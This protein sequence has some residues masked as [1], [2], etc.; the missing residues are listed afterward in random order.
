MKPTLMLIGLGGLGSALLDH[1]ARLGCVGRI[2]AAG[3]NPTRGQ[4]RCNLA[5][6]SA[7]A[8]GFSPDIEFLPLDL[9]QIEATAAAVDA[10]KPDIIFNA[11]SLQTWWLHELLPAEAREPLER[12][13]FGMW[14]PVHLTLAM[15]LM[16]ALRQA[17]YRGVT[18]TAPFPDVVNNILKRLGLAPTAGV[19]NLEEIV[20]KIQ[21]LAARRLN[22]ATESVRV[23]LV[24]HHA[25][26]PYAFKDRMGKGPPFFL[27]ISA[28]KHDVQDGLNLYELLFG[29]YSLPSGPVRNLLTAACS[30]RLI[31]ALCQEEE[32]RLHVPGPHGLPGGYPVRVRRGEILTEEIDGLPLEQAISINEQSHPFDGIERIESDGTAVFCSMDVEALREALGYDCPSLAPQEAGERAGE[33]MR[34]FR[35][36]AGRF[37][38]DTRRYSAAAMF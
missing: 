36:Y 21:I 30:A 3:R 18:I 38:V 14:L 10:V 7:L 11:A 4:A 8:M 16:Q 1:V 6:V 20:P 5:R 13:R 27:R 34:R 35:E 17:G 9:D 25:L 22:V 37:G 33:L 32:V 24:A 15:K 31:A 29:A 23:T 12:A 26:E 28:G 19:G 2:V